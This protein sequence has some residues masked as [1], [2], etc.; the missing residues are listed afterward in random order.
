MT[1][2][3]YAV[4]WSGL[5]GGFDP[6]RG[7]WVVRGWVL[8]AYKI[9]F[10]LSRNRVSPMTV[11]TCG[12]LICLGVPAAVPVSLLLAALLVLVAAL[13]DGLDGAVAVV[14]GR[15]TRTGFVYDSVADRIG[16]ASWLVAFWLAGAPGWLVTAAGAASWLHEYLRARAVAAGMSEIGVITVAERPTRVLIA[17]LGLAALAVVDLPWLP[18]ALWTALQTA[19]LVQLSVVVHRALR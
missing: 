6:R 3:E 12:L 13:A 14:S 11:T 10:W 17:G 2:D 5:H 15:V 7:S 1:W 8:A 9:G 4:A 16:E 19:G 18:P